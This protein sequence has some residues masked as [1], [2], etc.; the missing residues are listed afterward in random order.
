MTETVRVIPGTKQGPAEPWSPQG[1]P[2]E[3]APA[4]T[5]WS[6]EGPG[7]AEDHEDVPPSEGGGGGSGRGG[8]L[9]ERLLRRRPPDGEHNRID[10]RNTWQ[11]VAGS[12]LVPL[13][14]VL[15]LIAWYGSAHTPYVQQQIPYL[16]SGSFAGL[17]CMLLGGLLYWAHWLYRLY[18]QADHHHDEQLQV[19]QATLHAIAQRLGDGNGWTPA[20]AAEGSPQ[21]A[22]SSVAQAGAH[23]GGAAAPGSTGEVSRA[24]GATYVVTS[25]GSVY[26]LPACPIIAHHTEGLRVLGAGAVAHLEACRICLATQGP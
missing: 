4:P 15:I 14:I 11:I 12:I 19:M 10:L 5:S 3:E 16:V 24:V 26:H 1:A 22:G 7:A 23:P 25:T 18:D 2:A 17:G 20:P 8:G 9:F 13:G 21:P 6:Y